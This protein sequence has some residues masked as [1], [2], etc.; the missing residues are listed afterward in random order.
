[1]L[2]RPQRFTHGDARP[3]AGRPSLFKNQKTPNPT[4]YNVSLLAKHKINIASQRLRISRS[5]V[6]ELPARLYADT[7][8]IPSELIEPPEVASNSDKQLT[9]NIALH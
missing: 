9:C 6:V 5:D 4:T 2:Q 1:M 7:L 3:N 8:R